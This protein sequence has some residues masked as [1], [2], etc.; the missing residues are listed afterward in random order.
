MKK[1]LSFLVI[2][3]FAVSLNANFGENNNSISDK[4]VKC[5][6]LQKMHESFSSDLCP[7][8]NGEIQSSENS[9]SEC[10]YLNHRSQTESSKG[11]C[12]FTGKNK[13]SGNDKSPN[14]D[15]P[16]PKIKEQ[17]KTIKLK[18]T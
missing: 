4:E 8:L 1:L 9:K 5:P 10:P 17:V 3:L 7:Y 11:E 12:P 13:G 16:K 18:I 6:Y 2:G 15:N 14:S